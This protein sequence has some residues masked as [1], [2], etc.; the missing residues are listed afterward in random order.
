MDVFDHVVPE[1]PSNEAPT[2][3]EEE[4][5]TPAETSFTTTSVKKSNSKSKGQ[6]IKRLCDSQNMCSKLRSTRD[7][8]K[9]GKFIICIVDKFICDTGKLN[10]YRQT[11][12]TVCK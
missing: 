7:C 11:L 8:P 2:E 4:E 10:H 12:Q 3:T 5:S 1:E 6:S 9:I